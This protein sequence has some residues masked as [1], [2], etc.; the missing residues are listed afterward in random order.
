MNKTHMNK[1]YSIKSHQITENTGSTFSPMAAMGGIAVKT[2]RKRY[3]RSVTQVGLPMEI[4][5][6][7]PMLT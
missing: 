2:V 6:A 1:T 4:D 3:R 7:T 5:L